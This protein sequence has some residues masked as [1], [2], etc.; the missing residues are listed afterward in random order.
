[1]CKVINAVMILLLGICSFCDI[2]KK[3]LPIIYLTIMSGV[4]LL[5]LICQEGNII[6]NLF[7]AFVGILFLVTSKVTKE[8]IGYGDGWMIL[9]L[10]L[11]LGVYRLLH[12]LFWG[13]LVAGMYALFFLWRKRW[14]RSE[15]IPFVPF[16]AVGCMGVLL[17]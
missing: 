9:N 7:G 14:R 3:Q 6:Y 4:S 13:S 16:L 5:T 12:A 11:W 2:R 8:A 15:T 17:I 1:M 10:G